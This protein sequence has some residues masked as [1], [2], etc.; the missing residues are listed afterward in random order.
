MKKDVALPLLAILAGVA[1]FVLRRLQWATGFE[2]DTGLPITGSPAALA[3]IT[4]SLVLAAVLLLLLLRRGQSQSPS[5]YDQAFLSH[6][7]G[8]RAMSHGSGFFLL[9]A[10]AWQ[11]QEFL[12]SDWPQASAA[13]ANARAMGRNALP[14]LLS[15][16]LL[17]LLVVLL[18]IGSSISLILLAKNNY[19]GEGK[20]RH[21]LCLLIPAYGSSLW[22]ILTYRECSGD[23]ILAGYVFYLLAVLCIT[24]ALY[25]LAT[26]AFTSRGR[27]AATLFFSL[28]GVYFS[29]VTLADSHGLTAT[30]LLVASALWLTTQS[31]VLLHNEGQLPWPPS[32]TLYSDGE[33]EDENDESIRR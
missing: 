5:G 7:P 29:I 30:L 8:V 12:V 21:S 4:L 6:D 13:A 2:A 27:P 9:I 32:P 19:L 25:Q 23:P 20:G 16:V 17:P 33:D 3:L 1:G 14:S 15:G 10:A 24:L 28:L 11:M 31:F 22:L 18:C 26:F